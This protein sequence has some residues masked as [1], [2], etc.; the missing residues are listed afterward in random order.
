MSK[1]II[2]RGNSASGKTTVA[3][4]LRQKIGRGTF[5][6]A[7][8]TVRREMLWVLDEPNNKSIGLLI[9]LV[10]YGNRHCEITILEGILN[11]YMY[12]SLFK[13]IKE[14][15]AENVHA[16]YFDLPFEET[17]RR[18]KIRKQ[19]EEIGVREEEMKSWWREKDY[20]NIICEK[21]IGSD[22]SEKDIVE[23]IYKDI[24]INSFPSPN[25]HYNHL[26]GP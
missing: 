20:L 22:S 17:L 12:L 19:T 11:S 13:Q 10:I 16:Y 14:L 24:A 9:D 5:L 8:D 15:Y 4:A 1:I 18:H 6:I 26:S 2:L 7:Q 23:M 21:M 25:T 3:N